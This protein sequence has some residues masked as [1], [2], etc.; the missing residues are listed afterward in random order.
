MVRTLQI[1]VPHDMHPFTMSFTQGLLFACGPF[2]EAHDC[3]A[4]LG[5]SLAL[6]LGLESLTQR[7]VLA[8][9]TLWQG[10]KP[11]YICLHD[12]ESASSV[13][14]STARA[15]DVMML[16]HI[17]L[18]VVTLGMRVCIYIRITVHHLDDA[19]AVVRLAETAVRT[20]GLF[21]GTSFIGV[22]CRCR[23]RC[24]RLFVL[25]FVF[26]FFSGVSGVIGVFVVFAIVVD[27]VI[28]TAGQAMPRGR[29]AAI[30]GGAKKAGAGG[31]AIVVE[32]A[33]ARG[34]DE[35]VEVDAGQLVHG[36]AFL[37]AGIF[38]EIDKDDH[39]WGVTDEL[40]R[41]LWRR[42]LVWSGLVFG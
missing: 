22:V 5:R 31:V 6:E 28:E 20:I 12:D 29:A 24:L 37:A 4:S 19:N 1:T 15:T 25:V 13:L 41:D 18:A 39:C 32:V 30:S 40:L 36:L 9:S 2:S 27:S 34:A 42:G 33:V 21:V 8:D 11:V 3:L 26:V 23:R 38:L 16:S 14:M 35:G 17:S 10:I 7:S